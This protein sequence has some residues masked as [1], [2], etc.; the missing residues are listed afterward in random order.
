MTVIKNGA[1]DGH[2]VE[3]TSENKACVRADASARGVSRATAG[4]RFAVN[5]G[6]LALGAGFDGPVLYFENTDNDRDF[7]IE[8]IVVNWNGG[9][10][11]HD[12]A[13]RMQ[14]VKNEGEPTGANTTLTPGNTN[15]GSP[16]AANATAHKWDG[17]G[18]AGMTG[19][20][21]GITVATHYNAQG[22]TE[23]QLGGAVIVPRGTSVS[24]EFMPE[25]AGQGV[26]AIFGH[27]ETSEV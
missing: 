27:Y 7:Y 12:R 17:T 5:T 20:A 9:D 6:D 23:I 10:T 14:I 19:G 26:G 1:G 3:V 22:R 2:L 24:L 18:T 13:L 21:A 4:F 11:N 16:R 15:F 8:S 25:E